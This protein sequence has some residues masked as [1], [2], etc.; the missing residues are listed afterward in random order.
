MSSQ[1][2]SATGK[3][4]PVQSPHEPQGERGAFAV[5]LVS[6]QDSKRRTS[7]FGVSG[8]SPKQLRVQRR[9]EPFAPIGLISEQ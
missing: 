6:G 8:K 2:R 5:R 3:H 1:L 4:Q 9:F 7:S